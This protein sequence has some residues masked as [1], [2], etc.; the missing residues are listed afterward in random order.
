LIVIT[1]AALM[2]PWDDQNSDGTF[3]DDP[4]PQMDD[5]ASMYVWHY[6]D[7]TH[8]PAPEF[9]IPLQHHPRIRSALA[10]TRIDLDPPKCVGMGGLRIKTRK[11]REVGVSLF[12]SDYKV[13]DTYYHYRSGEYGAVGEAID[14]AR[15][16]AERDK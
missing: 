5:I 10:P 13:D 12:S 14:A 11:G 3:A 16:D 2:R 15:T 7:N 9:Q 6:D 1:A 4:L 8:R